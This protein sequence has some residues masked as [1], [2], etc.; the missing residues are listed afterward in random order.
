MSNRRFTRLTN[1][2]DLVVESGVL[3]PTQK[4]VLAALEEY[5]VRDEGYLDKGI[6]QN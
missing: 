2:Y 3:Q 1:G 6:G 4:Q 5:L